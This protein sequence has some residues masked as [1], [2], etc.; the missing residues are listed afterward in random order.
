MTGLFP[1]LESLL[2]RFRD[3]PEETKY[4]VR[5][6]LGRKDEIAAEIFALLVFLC[7]GVAQDQR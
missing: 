3:H 5:L 2:Q 1:E 7:D 4:E 6:K